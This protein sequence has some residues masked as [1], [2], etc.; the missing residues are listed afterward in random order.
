MA[1]GDGV[2]GVG[3][4][5]K[6]EFKLSPV[7]WFSSTIAAARSIRCCS[8]G[9][10]R[11]AEE[12][13]QVSLVLRKSQVRSSCLGPGEAAGA[14]SCSLPCPIPW[15]QC[16]CPT[17]LLQGYPVTWRSLKATPEWFR[18]LSSTNRSPLEKTASSRPKSLGWPWPLLRCVGSQSQVTSDV[19]GHCWSWCCACANREKQHWGGDA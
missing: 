4:P 11:P 18:E 15:G 10:V 14:L 3:E 19:R 17:P 12:Q 1:R 8:P 5:M 13:E 6:L 2:C 16:R 7:F 9:L